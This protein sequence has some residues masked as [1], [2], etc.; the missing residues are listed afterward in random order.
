M[1]PSTFVIDPPTTDY[2]Y[3]DSGSEYSDSDGDEY[4]QDSAD[5]AFLER[6]TKNLKM[7]GKTQVPPKATM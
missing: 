2:E 3:S 7:N 4:L 5:I 1:H 6:H